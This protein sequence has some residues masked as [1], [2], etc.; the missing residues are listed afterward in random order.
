MRKRRKQRSRTLGTEKGNATLVFHVKLGRSTGSNLS[1]TGDS[2]R[3]CPSVKLERV[4]G[5][6]GFSE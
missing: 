6:A 3:I 5:V 2:L 4:S 1:L